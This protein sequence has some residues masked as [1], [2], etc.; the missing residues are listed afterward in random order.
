VVL[1]AEE[2][3]RGPEADQFQSRSTRGLIRKPNI[4]KETFR[5]IAMESAPNSRREE[6]DCNANPR[7]HRSMYAR[8]A[9]LPSTRRIYLT[10]MSNR[11]AS[12]GNE[13][14]NY[15]KGYRL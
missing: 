6:I 15:K 4:K 13:L 11:C 1:I 9:S 10:Q 7:N 5:R 8:I 14:G 12:S 2:E 3:S